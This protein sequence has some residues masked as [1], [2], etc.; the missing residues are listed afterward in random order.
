MPLGIDLEL[1][2]PSDTTTVPLVRHILQYTLTEFGVQAECVGDVLLAVTEACANVV[3]HADADDDEY[4][5]TVAVDERTCEIRVIDTGH[6]FD[7]TLAAGYPAADA[8]RGRGLHL[9]RSL[10]DSLTFHSEPERGTVVHL[11]KALRFD[12]APLRA[13]RPPG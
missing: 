8:E 3:E 13:A 7:Q 4:R 10:M 2:L 11:T 12:V 5:I 6:G 9:M 1:T